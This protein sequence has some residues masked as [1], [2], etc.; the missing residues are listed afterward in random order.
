MVSGDQINVFILAK[1]ELYEPRIFSIHPGVNVKPSCFPFFLLLRL[2]VSIMT[3]PH[4]YLFFVFYFC[5]GYFLIAVVL[6]VYLT[7]AFWVYR[8]II[9]DEVNWQP[10]DKIVL[11]S[12]SY[13]PHEAEVLT[14]K[15]VKGHHIRIYERLS[16][17]H[18][19]KALLCWLKEM[20]GPWRMGF[21]ADPAIMCLFNIKSGRRFPDYCPAV[22][23][24]S[25]FSSPP[26]LLSLHLF[27]PLFLSHLLLPSFLA[28]S[29]F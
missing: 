17:R 16:H 26:F 21:T 4:F 13:E 1:Q 28:S 27:S 22:R 6:L 12:S 24:F 15:E 5:L 9:D 19:G 25:Q 14:V 3:F 7:P 29:T 20:G 10:H 18:I 2:L 23:N 11:S 8:I